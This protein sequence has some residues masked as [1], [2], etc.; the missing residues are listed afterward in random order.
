MKILPLVALACL[1][2]PAAW[3]QDIPDPPEDE[4]GLAPPRAL[5][6]PPQRDPHEALPQRENEI[7]EDFSEV[8]KD[9]DGELSVAEATAVFPK[10]VI[11]VDLDED[12]ILSRREVRETMPQIDFETE[13]DDDAPIRERDYPAILEAVAEMVEEELGTQH[14]AG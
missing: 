5:E 6:Y 13:A 9:G 11:L 8:D 4:T 1:A 14:S 7:P 10:S 12:G 3:A 2:A